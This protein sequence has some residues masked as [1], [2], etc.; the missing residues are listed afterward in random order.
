[1]YALYFW[2]Q[3]DDYYVKFVFSTADEKMINSVLAGILS[4]NKSDMLFS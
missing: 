4:D 2:R 1:M 3:C